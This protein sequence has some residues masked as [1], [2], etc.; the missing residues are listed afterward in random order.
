[1]WTKLDDAYSE[2]P[3]IL[4]AGPLAAWLHTCALVYC[5]R[6]LTDGFIPTAQVRRL[7]DVKNTAQLAERLVD[8][9]LWEHVE[10]GYAIHDWL[11][12]NKSSAEV[13]AEKE[14]NARRQAD[15]RNSHR[16]EGTGAYSNEE[17][18]AV[19]NALRNAA[20]RN[21]APSRPIPLRDGTKGKE[22]TDTKKKVKPT[23]A[24]D[25]AGGEGL[26]SFVDATLAT[27]PRN[28]SGRL[29]TRN[30]AT[31]ALRKIPESKRSDFLKAVT[32][33]RLEDQVTRGFVMDIR[34]FV[35]EWDGFVQPATVPVEVRINGKAN[36]Q[37]HA[38]GGVSRLQLTGED[39]QAA[40]YEQRK[41]AL[42][43]INTSKGHPAS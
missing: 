6:Y 5:N 10:E 15:W 36:G 24:P 31:E 34:R 43:R 26:S 28:R 18:N 16:N 17:S 27:Y 2:H 35:K 29:P 42:E 13:K 22:S 1:M 20:R 32:H 37:V 23:P 21:A 30:I 39:R 14:A 8:V 3:K 9:G 41:A 4:A 25:G 40:E 12:C 19:S 7:A 11:Q 33:Y 38:A